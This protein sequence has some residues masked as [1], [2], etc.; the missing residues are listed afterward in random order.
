MDK[1]MLLIDKDIDIVMFALPRWDQPISSSALSLARQL[2]Q[3]NR[4]F[5]IEHPFSIKDFLVLRKTE[6][7]K[8]RRKALLGSKERYANP[9]A[10][11]PGL[12]I[13]YPPVTIPVNFLPNGPI[14][15]S[16]S[17]VN[18]NIIFNVIRS[19][20]ADFQLSKWIYFNC[21]NPF[22]AREFPQDLKPELKIYLS[23]DDISQEAYTAKHGL[24]LEEEIIK[25]FDLIMGTSR[26]L[27]RLK[28][29]WN[30]NTF[31]LPNAADISLFRKAHTDKLE[32]PADLTVAPGKKTVG[33][34]G[35]LEYRT[36]FELIVKLLEAHNDKTFVFVGPVFAPEV[37][38]LGLKKYPNVLFVGSKHIS[39][40]P[41][42]LQHLDVLIIPFKKNVLTKS[43][44]PLK[45]NEYLGAGKPVVATSFSEDIC[46]FNDVA[47]IVDSHEE[48]VSAIDQ[49]ITE[50]NEERARKRVEKASENTWVARVDQFWK[51]IREF[52]KEKEVVS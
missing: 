29:N 20:E 35:S 3:K 7:V 36:D 40:L 44:Y 13:V 48:F 8:R 16:L 26:E 5:Y 50:H 18:D 39:Q 19:I 11:A 33:F 32:R 28:K 51:Y 24:R 9:Y 38:K 34:V 31:F 14:Y 47:Y 25:K 49:A 17:L 45:I 23:M 22:F 12:T 37:E 27:T 30:P 15:R 41:Y 46:S 6:G 4:V 10:D 52:R 43:I 1:D 42:Y 21:Y 2:A